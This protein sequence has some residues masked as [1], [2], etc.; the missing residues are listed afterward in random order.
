MSEAKHRF[1]R[2]LAEFLV[3]TQAR[4]SIE[5]EMGKKSAMEWGTLR[6]ATPLMGYPTVDEAEVTLT[7]FLA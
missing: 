1:I 7:E 4:K 5:L 3:A 6:S 2:A